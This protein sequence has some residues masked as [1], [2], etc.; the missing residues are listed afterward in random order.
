MKVPTG[1]M[2]KKFRTSIAATDTTIDTR[3]RESVAVART[4][5]SSARAAVVGLT[6]NM[7]KPAVTAAI[8]ARLP[9]RTGTSREMM[10]SR[11]RES[12]L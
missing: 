5:R 7:R 9:I 1:G 6:R 11:G 3:S 10:L 2:K 4:T 8:A 12:T